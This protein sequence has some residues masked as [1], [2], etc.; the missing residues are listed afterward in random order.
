[1]KNLSDYSSLNFV[2][3]NTVPSGA[4]GLFFQFFSVLF[5]FSSTT[6]TDTNVCHQSLARNGILYET[7]LLGH[8]GSRYCFCDVCLSDMATLFLFFLLMM[9]KMFY[10]SQI[11]LFTLCCKITK[12]FGNAETCFYEWKLLKLDNIYNFTAFI[13]KKV[14]I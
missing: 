12:A 3:Q 10:I 6:R 5:L 1:M 11:Y 9:C 7:Y 13:L 8:G 14:Q 4:V 2:K